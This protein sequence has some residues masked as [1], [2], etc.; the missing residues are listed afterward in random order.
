MDRRVLTDR[1]HPHI[2]FLQLPGLRLRLR[3]LPKKGRQPCQSPSETIG[4]GVDPWIAGGVGT[5]EAIWVMRLAPTIKVPSFGKIKSGERRWCFAELL[6]VGRAVAAR[7]GC[8]VD[9]ALGD[10]EG[11]LSWEPRAAD[12]ALV[13]EI[14][15]ISQQRGAAFSHPFTIGSSRGCETAVCALPNNCSADRADG[16]AQVQE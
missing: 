15:P 7:R 12:G 9:R 3:Q 4:S 11:A 13:S 6:R 5:A 8:C 1:I 10:R 16:F 14:G 2:G